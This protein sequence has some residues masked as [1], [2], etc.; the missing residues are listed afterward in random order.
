MFGKEK[1]M[2]VSQSYKQ[3]FRLQSVLIDSSVKD[4]YAQTTFNM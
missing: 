3:D 1:Q 4:Y 2:R